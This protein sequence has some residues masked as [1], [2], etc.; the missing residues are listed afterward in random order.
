MCD[1]W[2]ALDKGDGQI[3]KLI[4]VAGNHELSAF[5]HSF[6]QRTRKDITDGHLWVSVLSRPTQ[7]VF[8]RVGS[9]NTYSIY[10]LSE[11]VYKGR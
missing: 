2:L 6:Y 11:C 3:E 4:P 5:D 9:R 7:S 1:E 8:T 10:R